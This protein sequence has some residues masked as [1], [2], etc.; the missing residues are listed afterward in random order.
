MRIGFLLLQCR[1]F[2]SFSFS[3]DTLEN[4]SSCKNS[5]DRF[6]DFAPPFRCAKVFWAES[7]C[8]ALRLLSKLSYYITTSRKETPSLTSKCITQD[9][10]YRQSLMK[11]AEKYAQAG[12][13]TRFGRTSASGNSAGMEVWRPRPVS[14]GADWQQNAPG[15][16]RRNTEALE[17][18]HFSQAGYR[19]RQTHQATST[20]G[21]CLFKAFAL[22]KSKYTLVQNGLIFNLAFSLSLRKGKF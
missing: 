19:L 8:V 11:Y 13:T 14:P 5:A 16:N 15:A 22:M 10:A 3:S 18:L 2:F 17:D 12:N 1:C 21:N 20:N 7:A 9:M 6:D 4:F